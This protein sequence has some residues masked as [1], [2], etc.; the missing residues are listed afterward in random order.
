MKLSKCID[1]AK[2]WPFAF[3]ECDAEKLKVRVLLKDHL[4]DV[5]RLS[6][7]I[8]EERFTPAVVRGID[9]RL[10]DKVDPAEVAYITG[11]IHDLGKAS[12][13]YLNSFTDRGRLTFPY[14]ELVA[15]VVILNAI[16]EYA[17][18]L[19]DHV[20][21]V[22][23]LVSKIISRHHS[24]MPSRHPLEVISGEGR[25]KQEMVR[26]VQ[27]VEAMCDNLVV[28]FIEEL[29][30]KCGSFNVCSTILKLLS[31]HLKSSDGC[32]RLARELHS[33]IARLT[34]F[35]RLSGMGEVSS[36]DTYRLVAI[37]TGILMVADNIVATKEGRLSDDRLSPLY[38][39][40]WMKEL[41]EII[42][43]HST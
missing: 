38:V 15:S 42:S 31:R 39:K 32:E 26:I 1:E 28:K 5:A 40:H 33:L 20:L 34:E 43:K 11:L 6:K 8:F 29:L 23:D 16:D 14:H 21:A 18:E 37:Y 41:R 4:E 30:S 36:E 27:A 22:G 7:L 12:K 24:A 3:A 10:F 17:V 2:G 35:N 19:E 13:Y 9:P 25:R